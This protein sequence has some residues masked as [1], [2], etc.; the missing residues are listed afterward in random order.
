MVSHGSP[1]SGRVRHAPT[2]LAQHMQILCHCHLLTVECA[3]V[4]CVVNVG[5]YCPRRSCSIF[6][7]VRYDEPMPDQ[8]RA[9]DWSPNARLF[10]YRARS[11]VRSVVT[12]QSRTLWFLAVTLSYDAFTESG[13]AYLPR[14]ALAVVL[15]SLSIRH[16][17]WTSAISQ[18]TGS[19]GLACRN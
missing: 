13:T 1:H 18:D 5:S 17:H 7:P 11:D 2:V 3:S 9:V 12:G 15:V 16:S 6:V 10:P 14:V 4:R 8:T 19:C